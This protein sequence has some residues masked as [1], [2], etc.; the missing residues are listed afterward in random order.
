LQVAVPDELLE[1]I[2]GRVAELLAPLLAAPSGSPWLT[3]T[4]AADYLRCKPKRVYDL[5]SQRRIPAH[6][7]GGRVL[8]RRDELDDYL[9]DDADTV[10]TRAVNGLQANGFSGV[11]RTVSSHTSRGG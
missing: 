1:A 11:Q 7:D 6:R 10:L 2:A 8:L 3:V 9:R 4:E 5:I